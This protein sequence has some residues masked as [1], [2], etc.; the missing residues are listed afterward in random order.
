[1]V[2]DLRFVVWEF[3][4]SQIRS[5]TQFNSLR[6]LGVNIEPA[7]TM[8][9]MSTITISQM[10]REMYNNLDIQCF[11]DEAG[12]INSVGG[13]IYRVITVCK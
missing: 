1:M 5:S 4:G 12:G 8:S 9:R 10:A 7:N 3:R 2:P 6:D 13:E 11:S